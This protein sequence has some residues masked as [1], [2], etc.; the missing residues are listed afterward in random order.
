VED[1]RVKKDH[2]L[3]HL[4][5]QLDAGLIARRE[6]LRTEAVTTGVVGNTAYVYSRSTW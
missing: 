2:G 3:S 4:A 5:E 1:G 6:F